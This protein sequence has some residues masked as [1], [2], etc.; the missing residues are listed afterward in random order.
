MQ[1]QQTQPETSLVQ[2]SDHLS[3]TSKVTGFDSQAGFLSATGTQTSCEKS[4]S[5]RSAES[6]G[7]PPGTPVSAHRESTQ[8]GLGDTGPQ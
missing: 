1:Q 8:G 2:W 5:L 6:H 4:K 7:F 3:F